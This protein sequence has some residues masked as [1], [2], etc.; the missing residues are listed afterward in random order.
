MRKS[1]KTNPVLSHHWGIWVGMGH[2]YPF[3]G[4]YGG[5]GILGY[6]AGGAPGWKSE[7][8]KSEV[9]VFSTRPTERTVVY[10][11]CIYSMLILYVY[12][13]SFHPERQNHRYS[14]FTKSAFPVFR[15]TDDAA[16]M[17]CSIL[18]LTAK[19]RPVHGPQTK[20][21]QTRPCYGL[22]RP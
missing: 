15:T 11:V 7:F 5:V 1:Y 13:R 3:V 14:S 8:R 16:Y 22:A 9:T 2:R 10:T 21:N 4:V 12:Y 20:P 6:S 19:Q 17:Y 18:Q